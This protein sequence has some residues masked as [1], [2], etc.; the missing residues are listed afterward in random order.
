[1]SV[2]VFHRANRSASVGT[3][4]EWP[5]THHD[6]ALI[7]ERGAIVTSEADRDFLFQHFQPHRGDADETRPAVTLVAAAAEMP[8]PSSIADM[9]L[10]IGA[11]LGV[12][13]QIGLGRPMHPSRVIGFAPNHT[14]F[15]TPP[16]ED[17][18]PTPLAVNENVDVV[19]IASQAVYRF[20]CT[21][22]ALCNYPFNYVVMSK[23]GVIR[24]L[25]ERRSIRVRTH[26]PVRYGS[27]ANNLYDGLA[28]ADGIS[29]LGLSLVASKVLGRVGER[30]RLSFLLKSGDIET[31]I[32]TRA[33]IR[34]LQTDETHGNLTTHGLE[35][36]LLEATQQTALKA[37]VFDRQDDAYIWTNMTR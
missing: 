21:V 28:L 14:L 19:A 15:V 12:R 2:H 34:N 33:V 9:H 3:P 16:L 4:L 18:R 35:F 36:D 29:A 23:P 24:R 6:G 11:L 20:T 17:G 27:E 32:Q 8:Q 13:S 37:Y 1:M 5:V 25:R 26:L 30:V 22:E 10:T 7:L 31:L